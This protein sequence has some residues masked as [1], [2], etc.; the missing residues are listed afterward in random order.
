MGEQV[1]GEPWTLQAWHEGQLAEPQH[2]P[3]TQLLLE[4]WLP[5]AHAWPLLF[6]GWQAPPAP[7]Q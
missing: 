3:S 4:H 6:F 5:I 2:T 7:V 1:P